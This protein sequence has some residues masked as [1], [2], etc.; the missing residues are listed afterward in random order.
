MYN[1]DGGPPVLVKLLG[2]PTLFKQM[3]TVHFINNKMFILRMKF[4]N[5]EIMLL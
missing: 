2:L 4:I 3:I 5:I 1:V